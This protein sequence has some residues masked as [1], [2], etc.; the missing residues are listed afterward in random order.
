MS[1]LS[2]SGELPAQPHDS[3]VY[4]RPGPIGSFRFYMLR[5]TLAPESDVDSRERTAIALKYTI[6]RY[7]GDPARWYGLE[8]SSVYYEYVPM[9]TKFKSVNKLHRI[10]PDERP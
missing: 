5:K 10:A 6:R 4:K 3:S 2:A 1:D 9:F 7:A 8:N